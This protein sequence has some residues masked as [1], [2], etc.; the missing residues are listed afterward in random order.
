MGDGAVSDFDLVLQGNVVCP[1]TVKKNGWVAVANGRVVIIGEGAPPAARECHKFSDGWIFPGAID[2]QVHSR[3]QKNQEGFEQ[4]TRAAAAGGVTTICDMPFDDD[5]LICNL[6]RFESKKRDAEREAHVDVALFAT[7]DPAVGTGS[8]LELA[9]AGACSFKFSTFEA[10]PTRFPRTPTP[11]LVEAFRLVAKTGLVA[12]AHNENQ[13]IITDM[14]KRAAALGMTGPDVH[15]W[16][17]PPV[18]EAMAML[19]IYEAGVTAGVHAHVVHCSIARG[20]DICEAY[21]RQGHRTSVEVLLP[22]LFL[23]DEDVMRWGAFAKINPPIR[24]AVER[25]GLWAHLTAG[26]VDLVSTD[27]VA[28]SRERKS[29]PEM[30][31]NNSGFPGLELLL[32]LF[33]TGCIERGVDFSTISRC[34]S[35]NP[36]RHFRLAPMKGALE[37]GCDADIAV[38]EPADY[39]YDPARGHTCV[40]WSPYTGRK[41]RARVAATWRRGQMI[42][43]GKDVLSSPGSGTFVRPLLGNE[44]PE[45]RA[46]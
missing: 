33:V 27:H 26:H 10:H 30:L 12:C 19:E 3:S 34:L 15:A 7:I 5:F 23:T 46:G 39:A 21:K 18:N 40:D 45:A 44:I 36:A 8:I 28:W 32:P 16:A 14:T 24:T 22:F 37:P 38:V 1:D 31:K 2:S 29:N 25:E 43:D 35:F 13:E 6:D 20:I 41:M 9:K 4:S 17:R 11:M 42:F